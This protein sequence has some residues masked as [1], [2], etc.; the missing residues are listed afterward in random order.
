VIFVFVTVLLDMLALGMIIPVLPK[1]VVA[2]SSGDMAHGAEMF[3]LMGVTWASM[4]FLFSP[5]Q[6]ALSD[7][8]GRR[9]VIL[10]SNLGLGLDYV[11][12]ALAPDLMWLFVGRIGSGIAAASVSTAFAYIADVTPVERRAASFGLIGVAFGVG[13]VLGPAVGGL[14]GGM[15]PRL[16]F[17]VAAG[18]SL[19]NACYGL[20][21]LPESLPRERRAPFSWRRANPAGSLQLLRSYPQLLG[22][23]GIHFLNQLA[24]V[25]LASATVLYVTYRYAWDE[26]KVGIMLAGVGVCSAAVQGGLVGR[27]VARFGDRRVLLAGLLFGA[28]GMAIFGFAESGALFLVG[29]PVMAL[30]G[31]AGPSLQGLMT[32]HVQ[33]T[34]QGR[35]QGAASSLQGIANMVGPFLF[36]QVF[37]WSIGAYRDWHLPGATFLVAAVLLIS[38]TGA[39]WR[40]TR[41]G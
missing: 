31:L 33:P 23:A 12:M 7:R 17:W 20:F 36:T 14:L 39:A 26:P 21:V 18:L 3:G 32:R 37:A 41:H 35:L 10:F 40:V 11:V 9:P 4:Q 29:V 16:P 22:L 2:F 38:A 27:V 34:E 6:G 1:L 28:A 25:V 5:V 24:H 13:F 15:D 30:W 19:A 8:F